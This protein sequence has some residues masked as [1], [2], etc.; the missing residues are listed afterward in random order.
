M[1][2]SKDVR[3]CHSE[4]HPKNLTITIET[5]KI[6]AVAQDDSSTSL[7]CGLCGF[8][9]EFLFAPVTSLCSRRSPDRARIFPSFFALI[10]RPLDF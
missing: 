7:F 2:R 8:A 4:T 6:L 3:L 10:S 5:E 1:S 9:R